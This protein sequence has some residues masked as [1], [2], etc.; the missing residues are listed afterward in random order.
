MDGGRGAESFSLE[1]GGFSGL[2]RPRW[3]TAELPRAQA[4]A[5]PA[6]AMSSA[7]HCRLRSDRG[8]GM[9]GLRVGGGLAALSL[10]LPVWVV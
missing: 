7:G 5:G 4:D 9:E 6:L 3:N 10:L 8:L 1:A 2:R